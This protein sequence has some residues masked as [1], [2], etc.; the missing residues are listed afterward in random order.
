MKLKLITLSLFAPLVLVTISAA[1]PRT[2]M[3]KDESTVPFNSIAPDVETT[4]ERTTI[5]ALREI[6]Q[7]RSDIHRKKLANAQSDLVD[8]ARLMETIKDN[9]STATTK[10]L[11]QI[12]RKHLEY[13]PAKQVLRDFPPIYSSLKTI[14]FYLPIDKAKWHIDRA[15]SYLEKNNKL[16]SAKE[17]VL[18]DKSLVVNEVEL[19]LLKMQR[20][21]VKAR[22]YLAAKNYSKANEALQSAEHGAIVI[23]N[24]INSPF[25]YAKQSL[26]LAFRNYS[27]ATQEET[28]SNIAQAKYYLNKAAAVVSAKDKEEAG[29]LSSELEQLEKKIAGE[30][31]V[32]ESDL[33]AVWEKSMALLER[34]VASVSAGVSE[35]ETTLGNEDDLIGA[36]LHVAY[37][38]IYQVTTLE[39]A[40]AIKELDTADSYLQKAAKNPLTG[41]ED[42]KRI[43]GISKILH[44]LKADAEM[45]DF[46]VQERYETVKETLTRLI[47]YETTSD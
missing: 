29:K 24:G 5:V 20:Y 37:A 2:Q 21:V 38:E 30:G 25:Y 15:A 31:K 14:S 39:P 9:L 3:T 28:G 19:P 16:E 26:W 36:Q 34:S 12:A 47:N 18:A 32:T 10:N 45:H 8:V 42:Q 40:K 44:A 6:A 43:H 22:R 41:R 46:D 13:E 23:Y 17:L 35:E 33:K 7:A 4:I 1:T 27:T 11:I